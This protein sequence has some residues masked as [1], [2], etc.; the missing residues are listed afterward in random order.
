ML[1][2]W[3]CR[4]LANQ[5]ASVKIEQESDEEARTTSVSAPGVIDYKERYKKLKQKLKFLVYENEYF[6]DLIATNQRRLLKVSRDR[7]FLLDRLLLYEKPAKDSSDS[8]ATDSSDDA[9]SVAP[10][11]SATVASTSSAAGNLGNQ[12][13]PQIVMGSSKEIVRKRKAESK[14]CPPMSTSVVGGATRGRKRKI[15]SLAISSQHSVVVK[16]PPVMATVSPSLQQPPT[17]D[18]PLSTAEITRQLQE[19]RPT[20]IELMSPECASAT[21]PATMLSDDSPSKCYPNESLQQLME[22]DSPTH[23]AAE[24]CVAMEYT[25]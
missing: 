2:G 24:E 5:E 20:P 9:E 13:Q 12:S 16:K 17:K 14:G 25:T 8:D 7:A 10:T 15:N 4:T 23:V 3:Y 6:Q 22:D 1:D 19:R 21:V 18:E 11:S